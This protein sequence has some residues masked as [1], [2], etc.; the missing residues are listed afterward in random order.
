M[1]EPC[2]T[3]TNLRAYE[4]SAFSAELA[5]CMATP[6]VDAFAS[7]LTNGLLGIG[8]PL[9][10]WSTHAG[11]VFSEAATARVT[12]AI[13]TSRANVLASSSAAWSDPAKDAEFELSTLNAAR[14]E[15]AV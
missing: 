11:V 3:A 1:G 7:I 6:G 5:A 15:L 4:V 14:R 10:C 8:V 2:D 12:W 13:W 9:R